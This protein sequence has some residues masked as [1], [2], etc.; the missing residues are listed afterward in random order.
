MRRVLLLS[1]VLTLVA[2]AVAVPT[3]AAPK[4]EF[5]AQFKTTTARPIRNV[6]RASSR[7]TDT[8]RRRWT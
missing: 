4:G 2:M 8:Y 5:K 7:A 3:S 6:E 1:A